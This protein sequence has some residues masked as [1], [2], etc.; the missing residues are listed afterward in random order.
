MKKL[1]FLLLITPLT[2]VSCKKADSNKCSYTAPGNVATAA[3]MS[4]LQNYITTNSIAAVQHPSGVYY[5]VNHTGTGSMPTVCSSI[6]M[7]YT[8]SILGGAVF[9]SNMSVTGAKF[10]LGELILALQRVL[11]MIKTGG[12]VTLYIPPSLGYGATVITD[13]YGNVLIPANSYL[14][15]D[16]ELLDVQ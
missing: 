12:S 8:G 10:I 7:K 5:V 13:H 11:P 2:F 9:D 3:E 15:F 1:F 4:F 14:R 16:I 6:T